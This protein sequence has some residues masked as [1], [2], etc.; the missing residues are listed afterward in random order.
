VDV[1]VT[2]VSA[3]T[4]VLARLERCYDAIPRTGGARVEKSGPFELFVRE[5]PGWPYYARPRLGTTTVTSADVESLRERQRELGVPEALEW[6]EDLTPALLPAAR[7]AGLSVLLAP[8]MV[9][10]PAALPDPA[11][12]AD[13]TVTLLDPDGPGFPDAYAR[14]GAVAQIGFAAAGTGAGEA[15]PV[16][17]D[18][19]ATV[20]D[21]AAVELAAAAI[22]AG[23]KAQAVAET[24]AEGVLATGAFQGAEGAA[25]VVG[26]AT[27]PAA[28]RRGLGAAVSAG[29]ARH[30]LAIGYDLVFLSAASADVARVYA[31]IGFQRVGTACIAEPNRAQ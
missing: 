5:G 27:L 24:V 26:V 21:P 7:V 19:A 9:L 12:L 13:A 17:R 14:S 16:E 28:R 22:R 15:G 2:G 11:S 1:K 3:T 23:T 8:L 29:L 18:A 10:D 20:P 31:R 25:E 30:A 6:V 4:D